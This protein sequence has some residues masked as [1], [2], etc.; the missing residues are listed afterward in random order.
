MTVKRPKQK[1]EKVWMRPE[2][3]ELQEPWKRVKTYLETSAEVR[4]FECDQTFLERRQATHLIAVDLSII[5]PP[6]MLILVGQLLHPSSHQ[7]KIQT[8]LTQILIDIVIQIF[9]NTRHLGHSIDGQTNT[10]AGLLR[11]M[12]TMNL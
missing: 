7:Q 9:T 11:E 12:A 4:V 8:F 3:T 6:Q 2:E 5:Q 10:D 1:D